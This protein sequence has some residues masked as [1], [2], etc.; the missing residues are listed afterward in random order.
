MEASAAGNKARSR[1]GEFYGVDCI[2]ARTAAV[3]CTT[4]PCHNTTMAREQE[5]RPSGARSC[6][7]GRPGER[8]TW[9]GASSAGAC[10]MK[11]EQG[12]STTVRKLGRK[13]RDAQG[14]SAERERAE[15]RGRGVA[16]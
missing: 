11:V 13:N 6:A 4:S 1:S 16:A 5:E 15:G 10:T 12:G 14:S 7:Q 3:T 9:A 8:A 2:A